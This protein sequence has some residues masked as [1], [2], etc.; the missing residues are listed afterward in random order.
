MPLAPYER[1]GGWQA[2]RLLNAKVVD[3]EAAASHAG[4]DAHGPGE[5]GWTFLGTGTSTTAG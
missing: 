1:A 5:I 4:L 2:G 3:V